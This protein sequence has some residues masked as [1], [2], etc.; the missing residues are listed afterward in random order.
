[1]IRVNLSDFRTSQYQAFV[2]I[3]LTPLSA[4]PI[5]TP[6]IPVLFGFRLETVLLKSQEEKPDESRAD[7][8]LLYNAAAG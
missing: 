8:R 4:R 5:H 2:N 6:V 3:T 1:M 7:A